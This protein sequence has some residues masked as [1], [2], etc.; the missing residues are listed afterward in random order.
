MATLTRSGSIGVWWPYLGDMDAAIIARSDELNDGGNK[1]HV[2]EDGVIPCVLSDINVTPVVLP[3]L[4]SLPDLSTRIDEETIPET[5][6]IQIAGFDGHILALTNQG[7]VLKFGPLF[8]PDDAVR[9]AWH[10]VSVTCLRSI[11]DHTKFSSSPN[12][13]N[14]SYSKR[15]RRG[16]RLVYH[17]L[18]R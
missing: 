12:I 16:A 11:A 15:T 7:H 9:G 17:L 5:K 3:P 1:V 6:I 2:T 8:A 4:P 10:Y 14:W 18:R 13:V